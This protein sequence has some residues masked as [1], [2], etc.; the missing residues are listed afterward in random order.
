MY[1]NDEL[2]K[3]NIS[4][5]IAT[6]YIFEEIGISKEDLLNYF[7][8]GQKNYT[9]FFGSTDAKQKEII[10]RIG[11]YNKVLDGILEG[12]DKLI[13]DLSEKLNDNQSQTIVIETSIDNNKELLESLI[14]TQVEH[15]NPNIDINKKIKKSK[16]VIKN[17]GEEVKNL[18]IK[19]NKLA[20]AA[21]SAE[22]VSFS[23][24]NGQYGRF[25]G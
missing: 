6:K 8:I 21:D 22:M 4:P 12:L 9:T 17:L 20:A 15:K 24:Q 13:S 14:E 16:A 19:R 25:F 18:A 2:V 5:N 3:K 10:S 1:I 11:N 23:G 7:I